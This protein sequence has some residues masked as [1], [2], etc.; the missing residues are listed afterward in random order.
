MFYFL[1]V[2]YLS[3]LFRNV[4][5]NV[6]DVGR[7]KGGDEEKILVYSNFTNRM[8]PV[9]KTRTV[10]VVLFLFGLICFRCCC[11]IQFDAKLNKRLALQLECDGHR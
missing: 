3:F 2:I 1:L 4:A 8:C 10:F 7:E 9:R 5:G 6:D 11:E